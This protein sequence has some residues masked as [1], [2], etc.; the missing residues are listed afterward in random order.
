MA[1]FTELFE[2]NPAALLCLI[3]G[4]KKAEKEVGAK[5]LRAAVPAGEHEASLS[6]T[7]D[8]GIKKGEDGDKASTCSI[9]MLSAMALLVKRMG[10]QREEALKILAE[11]IAEAMELES[12]K[13]AKA[14]L[15]AELGVEAEV[16]RIKKELVAALPRTPKAGTITVQGVEME[17]SVNA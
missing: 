7:F 4:V 5:A 15:E 13:G 14:D 3:E 17:V 2:T 9:P 16:K 8:A 1:G 10:F 11:V 12:N 6:L